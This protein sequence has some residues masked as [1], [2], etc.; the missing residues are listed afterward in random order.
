MG[1]VRAS[2]NVVVRT[3]HSGLT[4]AGGTVDFNVFTNRV[5]VANARPGHSALPFQVLGANA[6]GRE[7][8]HLVGHP[9]D[10]VAINDN[11]RVNLVVRSEHHVFAD[12]T[13][14]ADR[15]GWIDL[16]T[17]M[18]DCGW[19]NHFVIENNNLAR[20]RINQRERDKCFTDDFF[21]N[22]A[23]S[24]RTTDLAPALG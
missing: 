9:H 3:D 13:E 2:E 20:L 10:R 18:H 16:G 1:D 6:D 7:W 23:C 8:K 11:V 24:L 12:D 21:P 15:T 5:V 19:V 4:I 22:V 14:R 17:G